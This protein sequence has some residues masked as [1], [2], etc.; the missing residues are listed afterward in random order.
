MVKIPNKA[1]CVLKIRCAVINSAV[2][3]FLLTVIFAFVHPY[4]MSV[5][6]IKH[7]ATKK[8]LEVSCRMFTD[9]LE[10][11]LK[12][13][14]KKQVDILHPK[15]KE[16]VEKLLSEYIS[17][18]LIIRVNG[19]IIN[20]RFIGYEKEEEATWCY[21]EA[22]NIDELKKISVEDGLLY[23]YLPEQINMLHLI[24]N[25]KRQSSKVT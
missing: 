9:N 22:Q 13:I 18:H 21:L 11:A 6:E 8:T 10:E 12:K 15:S 24:V 4:Y 2:W 17:G 7:N 23:D 14:N 1:L 5:T 3:L 20:F 19:V 16:E 25:D